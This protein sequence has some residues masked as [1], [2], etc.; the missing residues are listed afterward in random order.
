MQRAEEPADDREARLHRVTPL[1]GRLPLGEERAI[2]ELKARWLLGDVDVD[3][4]SREDRGYRERKLSCQHL[5][6]FDPTQPVPLWSM[7]TIRRRDLSSKVWLSAPHFE[8]PREFRHVDLRSEFVRG[9]T[10]ERYRLDQ[11]MY[12]QCSLVE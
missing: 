6:S 9:I 4:C 7:R 11:M 5:F 12:G 1:V 2:V 3:R 8:P 10:A